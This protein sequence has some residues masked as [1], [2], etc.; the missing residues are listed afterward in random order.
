[1][2]RVIK[3]VVLPDGALT[4]KKETPQNDIRGEHNK[5]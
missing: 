5:Q 2:A 4:Q 3:T 1:M